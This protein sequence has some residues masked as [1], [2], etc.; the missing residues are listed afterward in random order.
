MR[1]S[2]RWAASVAVLAAVLLGAAASGQAETRHGLTS[3]SKGF[4]VARQGYFFV[5]QEYY[6]AANGQQ[7]LANQTYVEFQ[8][9]KHRTRPYPIV[10]FPGG[11]QTGTNFT[12]TPDGRPGWAQ[13]FLANGYAVYVLD[14]VGRGRA[15][16]SVDLYGP[17]PGAGRP[18]NVERRFTGPEYFNLWPQARL[19]TQWPGTGLQGDPWFDQFL[20]SQ[21]PSIN[22]AAQEA[23]QKIAGAAILDR[24]GP[25]ILLTH[26]MSGPYGWQVADARPRLVKGLL[27]VEPNG[28]PF[29]NNVEVGPPT[30]FQDGALE[31]PWGLT[32]NP[33]T[34]SPPV[35]DPSQLAIVREAAPAEPDRIRCWL[36]AEPA[37]QLPTLR[38]IPILILEGEA[39]YHAPYDHCTSRFL[40][41]AGVPNTYVPLG[42]VGITGNGHMMMLEKNN[43]EIAAFMVRWLERYVE[44]GGKRRSRH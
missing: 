2:K 35:T 16:W 6:T 32:R 5:G 30:W 7:F 13:F 10:M 37:R 40:V 23:R 1:L 31:R 3:P 19:H 29:F 4:H 26:S 8:I 36:Q 15:P 28:P 33:I 9:P 44:R 42:D 18:T 12:G 20:A 24:I 43:L 14:E 25:A 17:L 41:Q 11:G 22:A 39:S 34:Y 21:T 27:Q 38:G